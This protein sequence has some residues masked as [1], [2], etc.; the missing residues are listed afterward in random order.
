MVPS[1]DSEL[2]IA[3]VDDDPDIRAA[4]SRILSMAGYEVIEATDGA[5]GLKK[6]VA[7]RPEM[8]LLDVV[9]P[10]INGVEV[11]KRLRQLPE[12]AD[13]FIILMSAYRTRHELKRD[14]L[15]AGAD[16]FIE[17]PIY[18]VELLARTR[19]VLRLRRSMIAQQENEELF[20]S[21]FEQAAVGMCH[22]SHDGTFL[23]VNQRLCDIVGYTAEEL[24]GRTFAD[25]THPEDRGRDLDLFRRL[26]EGFLPRYALEKR[27]IR[28]DGAVIWISVNA[29]PI[30]LGGGKP[31]YF[32]GVIQD[33]TEHK[34]TQEIVTEIRDDLE[35]KVQERTFAL[36][37]MNEAL[38]REI[39]EHKK[40]EEGRRDLE[41]QLRLAQKMEAI[42]TLAG[43]IAHDF[44]NILG[45]VSGF[46]ELAMEKVPPDSKVKGYL[47]QVFIASRR[48]V[49]LVAQILEFSR[50]T[51]RELH[52]LKMVPLVKEVVKFLRA[53]IPATIEIRHEIAA[54]ED[55]ILGDVTQMHQVIMNLCTNA[56]QAMKDQG[57]ILGIRLAVEDVT[58]SNTLHPEL[59]PGSY[60]KLTVS[61]S[62]PGIP[63][64]MIDK[65]FDPFFTTKQ[66][67]DG[68]GLGLSV[69]HGIIK[70][71]GGV[72]TVESRPGEG[73][74][75]QAYFP[76]LSP[77][78]EDDLGRDASRI[79]GGKE[80]ILFVDDEEM[81]TQ[82]T[83]DM[84]AG[85]GYRVTVKT[86][87]LE[88]LEA[89]RLHPDRFDLIIT[90]H[91]MPGMT[92]LD[93]SSGLLS[94]RPD[95]PIILCT[96]Y[97]HGVTQAKVQAAG[98][99][100]VI[101]KPLVKRQLADV[102][103]RVMSGPKIAVSNPVRDEFAK[104]PSC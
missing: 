65:I 1:A 31:Q 21:T 37:K 63:A 100:E 15:E 88:A 72:I 94:I 7:Q 89:F 52:P 64:D 25:I 61:D 85:L 54:R 8:V 10:D 55:M 71:H 77:K 17:K 43:G 102:I 74:V 3:V 104:S 69:V 46:T 59:R 103:R 56:Y 23:R 18:P 86:D 95:I 90:D 20:R 41:K 81:L 34:R 32:M 14:A 84:L 12:L 99:R 50:Q 83:T 68:T 4:L 24:T 78:R 79:V 92:G 6:I 26:H 22:V 49:D 5:D 51:E 97:S 73:A 70:K 60:L 2:R 27:Y 48:A 67:G 53:S 93:L 66:P 101:M 30:R 33:I 29:S 82:L 36:L 28:K 87:G 98:I 13:M 42:G 75:F 39:E 45:A 16:D 38:Y 40:S 80:R 47:Q 11:C 62:G 19:T 35:K 57:G 9:M 96:G 76:L 91:T 58:L 44:N